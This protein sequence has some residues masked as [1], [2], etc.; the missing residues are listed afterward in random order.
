MAFLL[1]RWK[2]SDPNNAAVTFNLQGR[3]GQ[4]LYTRAVY[5]SSACLIVGFRLPIADLLSA[6]G[7]LELPETG[8]WQLEI[9][10]LTAGELRSGL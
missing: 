5:F 3:D 1:E 10:N 9:G 2:V 8:N 4:F 6:S 7:Q